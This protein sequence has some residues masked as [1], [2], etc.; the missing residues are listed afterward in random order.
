[1][2]FTSR[3]IELATQFKQMGIDWQ[4]TVG[5]YVYDATGAVT[6]TSPFQEHVYFLL[7]YNCFMKRVGGVERFKTIMTWLPTWS[8]AREILR[9]LDVADEEVRD[10]LVRSQA[11]ENGS[12]LLHLYELIARRLAACRPIL[13]SAAIPAKGG[14]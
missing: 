8:D 3:Q 13:T 1:M 9:S 6:P 4:P 7:N 5:N 12:E 10:E 2:R 11:F 14:D